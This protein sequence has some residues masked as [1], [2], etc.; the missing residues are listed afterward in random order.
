MHAYVISLARSLDRRAHI[1]S[2]LEKIGLDYEL[3]TAVDGRE[4]DLSDPTIVDP[5]LATHMWVPDGSVSSLLAGSAGCA[6]SHLRVYQTIVERDLESALVLEDDTILPA[7]LGRVATAAADHLT[8]AEVALLSYDSPEPCQMSTQGLVRL[9]SGHALALPI[10]IRQP[11][12]SAAYVI[13]REACERLVK[14]MLPIRVQADGW[15]FYYREGALD[16]VRCV[17][18]QPVL[19]NADFGST[20]GSYSLSTGMKARLAKRILHQRIPGLHQALSLRRRRIYR[21]WSQSELV[22]VPFVERPSRLDD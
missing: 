2:E 19:K 12:S 9:A 4:L 10:D 13:T 14:S 22:D 21:Q 8:G 16:R 1:T 5:A 7:D 6:L 3:V 15:W 11:R 20:I 18:P 17:T